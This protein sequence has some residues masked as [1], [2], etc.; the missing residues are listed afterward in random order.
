[1]NL[2]ELST[3]TDGVQLTLAT[4][5]PVAAATIRSSWVAALPVLKIRPRERTMR[6][7]APTRN[8]KPTQQSESLRTVPGKKEVTNGFFGLASSSRMVTVAEDEVPIV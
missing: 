5:A 7:V 8:R 6:G 4:I 3:P 2:I 1:M